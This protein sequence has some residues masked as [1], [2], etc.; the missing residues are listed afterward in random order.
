MRI[1][2]RY[3][4]YP[5]NR[6]VTG[7]L[8]FSQM[9]HIHQKQQGQG[10]AEAIADGG[11]TLHGNL[12]LPLRGFCDQL[13]GHKDQAGQHGED[14]EQAPLGSWRRPKTLKYRRP[15]VSRP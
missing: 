14:A 10:P 1:V 2:L 12:R 8:L 4:K 3:D 11:H 13:V 5:C 15:M 7:V 9:E 6:Q